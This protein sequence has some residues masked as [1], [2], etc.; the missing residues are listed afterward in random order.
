MRKLKIKGGHSLESLEDFAKQLDSVVTNDQGLCKIDIPS[1][2]GKGQV[3]FILYKTGIYHI[4]Y[5]VIFFEEVQ[6]VFVSKNNHPLR[7]IYALKG[8]V[9]HNFEDSDIPTYVDELH[10]IIV[11]GNFHT[12]H[13]LTFPVKTAIDLISIEIDRQKFQQNFDFDFLVLNRELYSVFNDIYAV[14]T[15]YHNGN[16][17][18]EIR[19]LLQIIINC[20]REGF[21][22]ALFIKGKLYELLTI[23]LDNYNKEIADYENT[24]FMTN[25]EVVLVKKA[26]LIIEDEFLNLPTIHDLSHRLLTNVNKLQE[27][28]KL[29]FHKTV[30][31][32]I[33]EL[34]LQKAKHL[35]LTTDFNSSEIAGEIGLS[36]KSYF[37]KIFKE[38]YGV[39]PSDFKSKS[40]GFKK[41][42]L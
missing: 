19:A 11:V 7:F 35:F 24:A 23:Q 5:N 38:K 32:Y 15:F 14:N 18:L 37:S 25:Q 33:Q 10:K 40:S 16:F 3:E 27:S 13:S 1:H 28:F 29:M 41:V 39:S 42:G 6:L 12:A 22:R 8:E 36:S 31:E 21:L 26:C 20:K 17:G 34:R 9:R 4:R 30:N 2:L